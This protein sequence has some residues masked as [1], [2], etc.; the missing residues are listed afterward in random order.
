MVVGPAYLEMPCKH[1]YPQ[2]PSYLH[3]SLHPFSHSIRPP[4]VLVSNGRYLKRKDLKKKGKMGD[5]G[6]SAA[7]RKLALQQVATKAKFG[8]VADAPLEVGSWDGGWLVGNKGHTHELKPGYALVHHVCVI[9]CFKTTV[10]PPATSLHRCTSSASTGWGRRA[11][12]GRGRG[13]AGKGP[14]AN[15]CGRGREDLRTPLSAAS[16]SSSSR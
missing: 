16:A 15:G 6:M 12:R 7:E 5:E 2:Q 13:R 11:Q 1:T 14:S 9:L 4:L 10:H 3:P 8:E